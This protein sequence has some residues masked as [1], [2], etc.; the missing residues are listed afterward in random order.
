MLLLHAYLTRDYSEAEQGR[1]RLQKEL[2]SER[3]ALIG[4]NQK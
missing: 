1:V 4:G 3:R 2:V